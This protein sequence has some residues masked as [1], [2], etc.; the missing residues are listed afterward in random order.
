MTAIKT[1]TKTN[2]KASRKRAT[3]TADKKQRKSRRKY[4]FDY[5]TLSLYFHMPQKEAAKCLKVATITVKRNCK[6]LGFGWPYR[7]NKIAA[8]NK[9]VLSSKGLAFKQLPID[10]MMETDEVEDVTSECETDTESVEDDENEKRDLG[11]VL[12][13]IHKALLLCKL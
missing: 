5:D 11:V 9:L 13:S 3:P 6:R 7:A 8:G 1:M 12:L 4:E 10:C 2:V